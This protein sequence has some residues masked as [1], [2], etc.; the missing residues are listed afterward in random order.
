MSDLPDRG[1]AGASPRARH[2]IF[3]SLAR[4]GGAG[5]GRG[6]GK[7]RPCAV[8][9]VREDD[10][11]GSVVTV[12]PITHSTP[13]DPA[14]AVELPMATKRRLGLDDDPSWIV[15]SDANRFIWPG[16]DLRFSRPGD[17]SSAAYGLL[18]ANVFKEMREKFIAAVKAR[19]AATIARTE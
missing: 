19:R 15:V 6:G 17:A 5:P 2:S 16:P 10:P 13:A 7:D 12:L 4:R 8:I 3:F 14:L 1:V 9:L 18:P 11:E